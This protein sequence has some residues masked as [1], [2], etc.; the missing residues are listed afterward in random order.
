M[1]VNYTVYVVK[2]KE[3][4][5]SVHS[6]FLPIWNLQIDTNNN[7]VIEVFPQTI[8][9]K[10]GQRTTCKQREILLMIVNYTV[11][12]VKIKGNLMSVQ[13]WDLPRHS[14]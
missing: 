4:V 1:I 13:F 7:Q 14:N 9:L 6:E 10:I 2:F 5:T 3:V 8:C 11:Y 12:V